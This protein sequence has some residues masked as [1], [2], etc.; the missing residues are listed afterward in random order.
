MFDELLRKF[1]SK[2]RQVDDSLTRAQDGLPRY[3]GSP[4]GVDYPLSQL[5]QAERLINEMILMMPSLEAQ[6]EL[7]LYSCPPQEQGSV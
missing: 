2:L 4:M 5:R 6:G 3:P 1:L 7:P